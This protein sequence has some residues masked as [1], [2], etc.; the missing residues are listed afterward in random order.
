MEQLV[1]VRVPCLQRPGNTTTSNPTL[2][3]PECED[4]GWVRDPQTDRMRKCGCKFERQAELSVPELY[5][6]ARLKDFDN[7]LRVAG[8][9][10]LADPISLMVFGNVGS[11]K[12]RF[13]CALCIARRLAGL[14]AVFRPM[15][16]L[17]RELRKAVQAGDSDASIVEDYLAVGCLFLDDIGS[18]ALTDFEV[19]TSL[20]ILDGRYVRRRPTVITTNWSLEEIALKMDDRLASRLSDF[21]LLRFEGRDR[22]GQGR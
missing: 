14:P 15:A 1:K 5:R 6:G 18:G 11:G 4:T 8:E 19:R 10:W 17:Y 13:A 3:C 16:E 20:E 22:R 21:A 9:R 2:S 12:T 7:R